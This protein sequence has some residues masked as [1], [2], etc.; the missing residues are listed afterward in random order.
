MAVLGSV[1]SS[2]L[3]AHDKKLC[4]LITGERFPEKA[5]GSLEEILAQIIK[6]E[7]HSKSSVNHQTLQTSSPLNKAVCHERLDVVL[8]LLNWNADP[9]NVHCSSRSALMSCLMREN[10]YVKCQ[11]IFK[12]IQ[13]I[14]IHNAFN[15]S[16]KNKLFFENKKIELC[17]HGAISN[18]AYE[19]YE[20]LVIYG[21][22]NK[23]LDKFGL[24][25]L[26]H[27]IYRSKLEQW[28]NEFIQK[29]VFFICVQK[30]RE[31]VLYKTEKTNK[32]FLSIGSSVKS[33]C[34]N[35]G[36]NAIE[37]LLIDIIPELKRE[38][39]ERF[40]KRNECTKNIHLSEITKN[41]LQKMYCCMNVNFEGV[42]K[43]L[44]PCLWKIVMESRILS[45]MSALLKIN[46]K[47][48]LHQLDAFTLEQ[49]I[50]MFL[51]SFTNDE[52]IVYLS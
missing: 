40:V 32:K 21:A 36:Y 27:A 3:S 31:M 45:V 12:D 11:S 8:L 34:T 52:M 13:M 30:N 7:K 23:S 39:E 19:I 33:K 2:Q 25:P 44:V 24:M 47:S 28:D 48:V 22:N 16:V 15:K 42:E 4:S 29:I 41:T 10:K 38:C 20:Q 1:N 6:V 43:V 50:S 9:L 35:G 49:I 18:C 46:V 51:S 17:L 5:S 37:L 14:L 26:H